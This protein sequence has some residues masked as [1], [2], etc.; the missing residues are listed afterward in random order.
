MSG[1]VL[2]T[3]IVTFTVAG[4]LAGRISAL[5]WL[6]YRERREPARAT[7]VS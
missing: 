5:A 1:G 4:V 3:A 2:S 6:H 7:S